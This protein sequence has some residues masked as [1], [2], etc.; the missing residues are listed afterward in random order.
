MRRFPIDK[1]G[2]AKKTGNSIRMNVRYRIKVE[3]GLCKLN[4]PVRKNARTEN[5]NK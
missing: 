3:A 2:I 4:N 5:Q 1:N